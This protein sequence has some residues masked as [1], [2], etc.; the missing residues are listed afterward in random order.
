MKETWKDLILSAAPGDICFLATATTGLNPGLD[1]LLGVSLCRYRPQDEAGQTLQLIHNVDRLLLLKGERYHKISESLMQSDGIDTQD[2]SDRFDEFTQGCTFLSYNPEFQE[3]FLNAVLRNPVHIYDLPLL[4]RGAETRM[5]W[6]R[7]EL[8]SLDEITKTFSKVIGKVPSMKQLLRLNNMIAD[9]PFGIL[10]MTYFCAA[11][12][13]LWEKFD[14][15][16]LAVQESL[17]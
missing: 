4:L 8:A 1:K 15:I 14:L 3:K 2:L 5:V 10:P 9:P 13:G 11:L 6:D 7:E 17:A 16:P 12:S